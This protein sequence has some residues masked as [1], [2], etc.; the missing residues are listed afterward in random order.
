MRK[1]RQYWMAMAVTAVVAA[2]VLAGC[3]DKEDE[4]GRLRHRQKRARKARRRRV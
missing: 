2:G 4:G 1:R 3:G